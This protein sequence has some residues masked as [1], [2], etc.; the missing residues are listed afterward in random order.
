MLS[1]IPDGILSKIKILM[2]QINFTINK[3]IKKQRH[4]SANKGQIY[5]FSSSHDYTMALFNSLK[6]INFCFL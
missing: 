1:H 4:Y 5:G 6:R 3:T 2:H